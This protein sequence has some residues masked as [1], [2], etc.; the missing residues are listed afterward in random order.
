MQARVGAGSAVSSQ[1]RG[2]TYPMG[3]CWWEPWGEGMECLGWCS[4]EVLLCNLWGK[5]GEKVHLLG[6]VKIK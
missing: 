2:K 5:G 4:M 6:Y 1:D 3:Q